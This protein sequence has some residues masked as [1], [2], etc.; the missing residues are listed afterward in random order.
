MLNGEARIQCGVKPP[1]PFSRDKSFTE[2]NPKSKNAPNKVCS[3]R[4]SSERS[5]IGLIGLVIKI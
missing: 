2:E 1:Q 5:Y 3:G 4:P